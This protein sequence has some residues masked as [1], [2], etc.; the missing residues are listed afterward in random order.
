MEFS[1]EPLW[2]TY[3]G[4]PP[5]PVRGLIVSLASMYSTFPGAA[6]L[7]V[8]SDTRNLDA[9]VEKF[10][11]GYGTAELIASTLPLYS[12]VEP[13]VYTLPQSVT[14]DALSY[15]ENENYGYSNYMILMQNEL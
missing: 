7:N 12:M 10:P 6:G 14:S 13:R 9:S 5:Q 3:F 11:F 8:T 2:I 1:N 15:Y 4:H